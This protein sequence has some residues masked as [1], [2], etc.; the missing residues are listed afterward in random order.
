MST[1]CK[2]TRRTIL[3]S[4]NFSTRPSVKKLSLKTG[5]VGLSVLEKFQRDD[6]FEVAFLSNGG[7]NRKIY[8]D[9]N[10]SLGIFTWG[11]HKII[12]LYPKMGFSIFVVFS[13]FQKI[14]AAMFLI[15]LVHSKSRLLSL[16]SQ[17]FVTKQKLHLCRVVCPWRTPLRPLIL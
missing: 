9:R 2:K 15:F 17:K 12:S 6:F 5:Q 7:S 1:P 11:R 4:I 3:V 13:N 14:A 8:R 10:C 16:P